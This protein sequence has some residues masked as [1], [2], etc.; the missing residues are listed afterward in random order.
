[1]TWMYR[2]GQTYNDRVPHDVLKAKDLACVVVL[3][4]TSLGFSNS[5]LGRSNLWPVSPLAPSLLAAFG[6]GAAALGSELLAQMLRT[7][8]TAGCSVEEGRA[9]RE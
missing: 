8:D 4:M 7:P 1:M 3:A 9:A 2:R 5:A 6:H